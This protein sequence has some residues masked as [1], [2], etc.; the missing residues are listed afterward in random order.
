MDSIT[1]ISFTLTLY[2]EFFIE[3]SEKS[4][5]QFGT[6]LRWPDP[7]ACCRTSKGYNTLCLTDKPREICHK[8]KNKNISHI[9]LLSWP[10]LQDI[11]ILIYA[12]LGEYKFSNH[13][14]TKLSSKKMC[15]IKCK[16]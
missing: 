5:R 3:I 16:D 9:Y 7:P 12:P 2:L 14:V 15:F 4:V 11:G 13:E 8:N 6:G 1:I 10:K